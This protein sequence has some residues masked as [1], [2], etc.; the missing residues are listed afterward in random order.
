MLL[1][2]SFSPS[3]SP[4]H[5]SP[6]VRCPHRCYSNTSCQQLSLCVLVLS[7]QGRGTAARPVRSHV[8]MATA[9]A[10]I[11]AQSSTSVPNPG[12]EP[13]SG[14]ARLKPERGV[15]SSKQVRRRANEVPRLLI[16]TGSSEQVQQEAAGPQRPGSRST[17][18]SRPGPGPVM[19]EKKKQPLR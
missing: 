6:T 13:R 17:S 19:A 11:A 9:A 12:E 16:G 2:P 8:T 18:E 4:S 10:S 15:S 3:V 5:L 14:H 1:S 7:E